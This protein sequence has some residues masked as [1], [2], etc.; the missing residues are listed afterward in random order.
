MPVEVIFGALSLMAL[1]GAVIAVAAVNLFRAAL[2]LML[3][4]VGIAGLFL[5]QQ[6]QFLAIVQVL[7]YVGGISELIVFAIMLTERGGPA[8]RV[9]VNPRLTFW[10]VLVGGGLAAVLALLLWNSSLK[11]SPRADVAARDLGI[12]LLNRYLIPFE[13]VSLLLLVALI[14]ALLIAREEP[15]LPSPSPPRGERGG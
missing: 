15:P 6:A 2:G 7:V 9:T 12:S 5:L 4:L 1:A 13:A 14:G 10:A 3:S 8:L 11:D